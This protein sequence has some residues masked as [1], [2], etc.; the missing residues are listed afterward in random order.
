MAPLDTAAPNSFIG[1]DAV[2]TGA[3][4]GD[5]PR[6]NVARAS[7]IGTAANFTQTDGQHA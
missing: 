4:A 6:F 1:V 3:Q 5:Q 2:A 7:L